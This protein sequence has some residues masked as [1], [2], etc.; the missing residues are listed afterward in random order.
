MTISNLLR[1]SPLVLFVIIS[2]VTAATEPDHGPET[3]S[4]ESISPQCDTISTGPQ[5]K[6]KTID[7]KLY[8]TISQLVDT[9]N[10]HKFSG[11]NDLIHH[12]L[13]KKNKGLSE[14][15]YAMLTG[16]YEKPWNF[17]VYRLWRLRV[18]DGSKQIITCS[19]PGD[20]SVTSLYGYTEQYGLLIQHMAQNDLSRL[21]FSLV[22]RDNGWTIGAYHQQQWTQQGW[23]YMKWYNRANQDLS[24]GKPIEAYLKLDIAQKMLFGGQVLAYHDKNRILELRNQLFS[25]AQ[26]ATLI[27]NSIEGFNIAYIGTTPTREGAAMLVRLYI[28]KPLSSHDKQK[29]CQDLAAIVVTR[30][31]D[32]LNGGV[33]CSFLLPNE[34]PEREGQLGGYYLPR[35]DITLPKNPTIAQ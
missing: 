23:D 10:S 4:V 7:A 31:Y 13:R 34:P 29:Q 5:V 24:R 27:S 1:I 21:Y 25:K 28:D 15:I 16:R 18:A 32:G 22:P 6:P 9:L 30:W 17:S 2:A 11:F 19:N 33:T 35:G 3:V 20:I 26:I 8:K 14:Q 12:R